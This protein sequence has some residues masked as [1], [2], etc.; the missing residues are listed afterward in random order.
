MNYTLYLTKA[1]LPENISE[2]IKEK[3]KEYFTI[4]DK[5]ILNFFEK[6]NINK[7]EE[8]NK[9]KGYIIFHEYKNPETI[10]SINLKLLEEY[11]EIKESKSEIIDLNDIKLEIQNPSNS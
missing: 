4:K 2:K 3:H 9:M 5:Q 11:I 6:S 7:I 8:K 10:N 1:K